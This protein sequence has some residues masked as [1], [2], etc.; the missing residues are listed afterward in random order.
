MASTS[1]R[2]I[3]VR[4]SNDTY[5]RLLVRATKREVSVGTYLKVWI[6]RELSRQ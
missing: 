5:H 4:V 6:E 2:V 1:S 3:A